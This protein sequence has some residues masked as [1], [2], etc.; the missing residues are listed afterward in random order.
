MQRGQRL[1]TVLQYLQ[2]MPLNVKVG[3][4]MFLPKVQAMKH[5]DAPVL[6][7][8]MVI[9]LWAAADRR[10]LGIWIANVQNLP[11]SLAQVPALAPGAVF[12]VPPVIQNVRRA[13]VMAHR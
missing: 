5:T 2:N 7:V 11:L 12:P 6:N 10:G 4:F 1:M 9:I 3:I 13:S 8:Q